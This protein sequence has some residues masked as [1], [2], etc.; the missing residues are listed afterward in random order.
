MLLERWFAGW[1]ARLGWCP[2]GGLA[3]FVGDEEAFAV[4]AAAVAGEGAVFADD[5]VAGDD[6]GAEVGG[7]GHGDAAGV[8][9][10]GGCGDALGEGGVGDGLAVG[11][12][13]EFGPDEALELGAEGEERE[14]EAGEGLRALFGRGGVGSGREVGIELVADGGDEWVGG[15]DGLGLAEELLDFEECAGEVCAIV[16]VEEGEVAF[17]GLGGRGV[18]GDDAAEWAEWGGDGGAEGHGE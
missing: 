14:C 16:E 12:A 5:A 2:E 9:G 11:D 13:L 17:E 7:V 18:G 6:D 3:G 1:L 4:E 8:G 15:G 10:A